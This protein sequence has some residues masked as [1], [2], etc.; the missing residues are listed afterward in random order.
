MDVVLCSYS[1][2]MI[3]PQWQEVILK[4]KEDLNEGGIMAV[5]DFHQSQFKWFEQHMG[6]NHVRM[7]GHLLPF[8]NQHF[9]A[10]VE[11]ENKAYG[12]VW[13]YLVYLG[14]K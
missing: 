1:L 6:N 9:N 3:N 5:T 13:E 14:R 2:T 4:A 7:D 12:G 8:L 11:Q 10:V